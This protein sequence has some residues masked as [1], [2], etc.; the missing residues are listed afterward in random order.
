MFRIIS[1]NPGMLTLKNEKNKR[2]S[3][4]RVAHRENIR[5]SSKFTGPLAQSLNLGKFFSRLPHDQ[6][7]ISPHHAYDISKLPEE[8]RF[9]SKNFKYEVSLD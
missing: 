8:H 1:P 2:R 3:G 6:W 9:P 7:R 4:Q 5:K